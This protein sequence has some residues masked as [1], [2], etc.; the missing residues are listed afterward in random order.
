MRGKI[1]KYSEITKSVETLAHRWLERWFGWFLL[2]LL[3][4]IVLAFTLFD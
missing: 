2:A 3:I 4:G 1:T